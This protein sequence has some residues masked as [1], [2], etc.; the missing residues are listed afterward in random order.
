MASIM[1]IMALCFP[2]L[3]N[4]EN[5]LHVALNDTFKFPSQ[6]QNFKGL[7]KLNHCTM[8]TSFARFV[9]QWVC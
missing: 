4:K 8:M 9:R 6:K 2:E 1:M 5:E 7:S 3:H